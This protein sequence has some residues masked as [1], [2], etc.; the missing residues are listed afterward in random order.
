MSK[1]KAHIR[2]KTADN[3]IVPGVTTILGLMAKP[4][5]IPWANK[6]GLQGIDVSK[7]VD[8]KADIG[9][10]G[11]ALVTDKLIKV[12]T[13]TSDYSENQIS[14]AENCSLSFWAWERS[15]PLKK[16]S[17]SNSPLSARRI[18]SAG[19]LTSMQRSM[20]DERLLI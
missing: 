10:L 5:L 16:F 7:Y 6:M 17:L 19:P 13:D 14:L 8:D 12:T 3:K 1:T 20:A 4:A 9:T 11:H 18:N 2:Y 15:I